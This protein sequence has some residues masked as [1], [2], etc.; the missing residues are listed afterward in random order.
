[1][2]VLLVNPPIPSFWYNDEY[3]LPS[4]MLYLG[5]SLRKHGHIPQIL[6]MKALKPQDSRGRDRFYEDSLCTAIREFLP[7]LI[8]FGC[9]FSGNFPDVLRFANLCKIQFPHLPIMAGGI[10]FTIHAEKIME[11]CPAFDLIILGEGEHSL[12]QVATALTA[13][14]GFAAIDGI[15]WRETGSVRINSKASYIEDP[16]EIPFPAYDLINLR[17]YFVDTSAWHNPKVLPINTSIPIITS[18]SCPLRCTFCS[19]YTVMGPR[20]RARS[21]EN[22]VQELELLYHTYQHRHFSIMD[23]NFTLNKARVLEICRLIRERGLDIQFETPNGLNLNTLDAEVMEALVGA[24]MVRVALAIESGSDHIRNTIMG[25]H[26]S[27]EKI[28]EVVKLTKRY[29]HLHVSAFFIIG[30]PEETRE[31]L[32]ATY[33]MIQLIEADKIQLMN[34]VPFPHTALFDQALRDGLLVD[35]DP[36]RL[37]LSSDLYFKN[38]CRFFIKPYR[39]ELAELGAFREHCLPLIAERQ[40]AGKA[41]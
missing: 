7:D 41:S 34:I 16:D 35:L 17:D 9:L 40:R 22:V 3:Y 30:M 13:G 18:R 37:Y 11:H 12:A 2:R 33:N 14:G 15:A 24:G 31:T 39:L 8:G 10:H 20:W 36:E 26:L 6:D 1:M 23:D 4:S 32:E 38:T 29:A 25:K 5:A 28:L 21:P 19:M 27:R